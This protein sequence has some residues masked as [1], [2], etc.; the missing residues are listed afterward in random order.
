MFI[1]RTDEEMKY[2]GKV[3]ITVIAGAMSLTAQ[4]TTPPPNT[5][6]PK[7]DQR[8]VNQQKRIGNGV[9]NGSLT[10]RE[11]SRLEKQEAGINK[12]E[13]KMKSDGNFTAAERARITRQQNAMSRRIYAQKHDAQHQAAA[14]NEVSAR[15]RLQQERIGQ[16]IKS[17]SLTA[18]ETAKLE[19]N[20][21]KLNRE[22]RHDRASGGGLSA[23]EK[24]KINAQQNKMSKR[25]YAKKHNA[26][27]R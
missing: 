22:V 27:A 24:A 20:E 2:L 12:E 14:R 3:L 1:R 11:T 9:E 21:A 5:N 23:D 4:T 15:Q 6:S 13:S 10:A 7:I 17:G 26:R 25:I 18:G 19:H 16:G 8:E